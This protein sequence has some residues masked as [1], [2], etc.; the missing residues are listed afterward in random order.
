MYYHLVEKRSSF[1]ELKIFTKLNHILFE[2]IS[3]NIADGVFVISDL[4]EKYVRERNKKIK[5]LKVLPIFDYSVVEEA[6]KIKESS[7]SE[8][9][10]FIEN[11]FILYCG[12]FA[13]KEVIDLIIN[14]Y[15]K[16]IINKSIKLVMVLTSFKENDMEY[17]NFIN[18][19]TNIVFLSKLNYID[20]VRLYINSFALVIPM[21]DTIQDKARM[22][23]K[24]S[25]Y[26]G[27]KSI[28]ITN[29]VGE[30]GKYF[31]DSNA[32]LAE[33]FHINS[34]VKA[35]NK[36]NYLTNIINI[37]MIKVILLY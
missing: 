9:Y 34:Y 31:N 23:N 24:I 25:E 26:T 21:R 19:N 28:I 14:S 13:Y 6:R 5:I 17:Q 1:K 30:L 10:S 3:P 8:T 18:S 12:S 20:L 36:L 22:P 11:K 35:F 15:N 7:I 32:I 4:L 16:S 2:K 29:I 27:T 37:I 33:S